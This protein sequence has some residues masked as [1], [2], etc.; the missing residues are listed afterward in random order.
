[1]AVYGPSPARSPPFA[2][3]WIRR[4]RELPKSAP[5]ICHRSS[6]RVVRALFCFRLEARVRARTLRGSQP[7]RRREPYVIDGG[8]YGLAG[9]AQVVMAR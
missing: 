5:P 4:Q 9:E 2:H 7:L 1:M 3:A 6:T 8:V